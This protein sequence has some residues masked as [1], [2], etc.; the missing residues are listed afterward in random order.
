MRQCL[1]YRTKSSKL[2][3]VKFRRHLLGFL[4]LARLNLAAAFNTWH[5][6][7]RVCAKKRACRREN[8]HFLRLMRFDNLLSSPF[9][10][11][12]NYK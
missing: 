11:R 4:I 10:A 3:C 1:R 2:H 6:A 12:L 9:I 5:E 7:S 8:A